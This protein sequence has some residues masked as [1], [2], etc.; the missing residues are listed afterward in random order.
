MYEVVKLADVLE[1]V[2]RGLQFDINV[3][4]K[5]GLQLEIKD[6]IFIDLVHDTDNLVAVVLTK[7]IY[8]LVGIAYKS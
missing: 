3:S 8:R 4:Q 7:L 6:E 5:E 2:E 1:D